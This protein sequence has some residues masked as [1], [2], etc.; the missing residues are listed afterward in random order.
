M[1]TTAPAQPEVEKEP[2]PVGEDYVEA[3]RNAQGRIVYKC[4]LCDCE[5]NDSVAKDMH[6]KGRRHRL[7]YKVRFLILS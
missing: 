3:L 2:E 4:K 5:F 6:L 1:K 7:N